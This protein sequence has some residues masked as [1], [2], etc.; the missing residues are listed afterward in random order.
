MELDLV[1]AVAPLS[2]C[3]FGLAQSIAT[4]AKG[5]Q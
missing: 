2:G 4:A 1:Q 3:G 5:M